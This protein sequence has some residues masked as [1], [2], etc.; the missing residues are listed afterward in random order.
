[1]V[2]AFP[3]VAELQEFGSFKEDALNAAVFGANNEAAF[4]IMDRCGWR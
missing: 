4:K 3:I 1:M 2:E